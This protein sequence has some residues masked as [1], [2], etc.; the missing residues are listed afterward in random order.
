MGARY[1]WRVNCQ[2][3]L[4]VGLG[5]LAALTGPPALAQESPPIAD[6]HIQ[7]RGVLTQRIDETLKRQGLAEI[8]GTV[9]VV[10]A[11]TAIVAGA[12]VWERD[13]PLAATWV[14][15]AGLIDGAALSSLFMTRDAR[16]SVLEGVIYLTPAIVPL[17]FAL[18]RD[19]DPFPRLTAASLAA[20]Y[21]T[22]GALTII[23]RALTPT[24]YS[25]LRE[26]RERLDDPRGLSEQERRA[27]H[28]TLLGA[29]GPLPKWL[30]GVPLIVAG[31]VASVPVFDGGYS[32]D[33]EL[34]AG[35]LG[36]LTM[37]TGLTF[38]FPG[39]VELYESDLQ[40]LDISVA[41]APGGLTLTG[42]F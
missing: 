13:T 16:S 32:K 3:R 14:V 7:H 18:A 1:L 21:A 10:L 20:G 28:Q 5:A 15:G 9:D 27:L 4:A 39:S 19:P 33:A 40:R 30:T 22:T 37:L 29:R 24:S 42:T 36:G 2:K 31:G 41:V 11:S 26:R 38:L 35:L 6:R 12:V 17:G 23:N 8:F 25:E 34:I